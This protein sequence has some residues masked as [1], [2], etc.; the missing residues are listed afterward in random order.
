[1]FL[2]FAL[3]PFTSLQQ[4]SFSDSAC[5][6][7]GRCHVTYRHHLGAAMNETDACRF[8]DENRRIVATTNPEDSALVHMGAFLLSKSCRVGFMASYYA[9]DFRQQPRFIYTRPP[10][11]EMYASVNCAL[12]FNAILD[13]K[14]A[15]VDITLFN[16]DSRKDETEYYSL[17]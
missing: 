14:S 9:S 7:S 10:R 15:V 3:L 11:E 4:I 13:A 12:S 17:V 5:D 1:M 6:I 16:S 2:L 8:I